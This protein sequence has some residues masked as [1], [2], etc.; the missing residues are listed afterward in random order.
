MK[1]SAVKSY[2]I[3]GDGN[4]RYFIVRVETDEGIHGLGEAG[5]QFWAGAI[6]QA[7]EHLSEL[8]IGQ[9]PFSTEMLWQ[10]H[11]FEMSSR[12][13]EFTPAR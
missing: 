2:P 10:Q 8:L 6:R 7:V 5:I 11:M 9:D 3:Q 4:A 1:I 12:R 13:T